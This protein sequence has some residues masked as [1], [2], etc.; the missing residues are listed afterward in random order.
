MW[1]R[2][3]FLFFPQYLRNI[4]VE[5]LLNFSLFGIS[6]AEMA[7][8]CKIGNNHSFKTCIFLHCLQS[9][10]IFIIFTIDCIKMIIKSIPWGFFT[11]ELYHVDR[12]TMFCLL[13]F[14]LALCECFFIFFF[15]NDFHFR[16][17]L[18][19]HEC[20]PYKRWKNHSISLS[21]NQL[22]KRT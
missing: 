11:L 13:I 17:Q 10:H 1:K 14:C 5:I 21:D 19:L 3:R 7:M 12:S 9:V 22:R 16:W 6:L 18:P 20:L 15:R 2:I 8:L 4:L